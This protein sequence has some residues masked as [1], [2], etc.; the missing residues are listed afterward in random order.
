MYAASSCHLERSKQK[1]IWMLPEYER[2]V[3]RLAYGNTHWQEI[4]TDKCKA[5]KQIPGSQQSK[6]LRCDS[7]HRQMRLTTKKSSIRLQ[8]SM[9]NVKQ[10]WSRKSVGE[11]FFTSFSHTPTWIYKNA[12]F[13]K[14][15]KVNHQNSPLPLSVACIIFE[16]QAYMIFK[17][18][19]EKLQRL[20]K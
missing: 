2:L 16:Y 14:L 13:Q 9:L 5:I 7:F 4:G 12:V 20:I 1:K 6:Y 8:A 18:G 15:S 17:V 3:W 19:R 10:Q 11:L